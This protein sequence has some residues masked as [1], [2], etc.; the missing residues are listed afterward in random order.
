PR[1]RRWTAPA[2][3]AECG[4]GFLAPRGRLAVSEPPGGDPGRWDEE[5]LAAL[6]LSPP[7][8]PTGGG[9]SL[10]VM[11]LADQPGPRWPRRPGVPA[12]RPI[13]R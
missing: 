9:A 6:G 2:L 1:S 8:L 5:G 13:W 10:A 7:K 3:T 4:V 12:R 11:T